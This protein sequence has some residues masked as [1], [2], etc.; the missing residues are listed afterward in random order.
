MREGLAVPKRLS[1]GGGDT[2]VPLKDG[3]SRDIRNRLRFAN[4]QLTSQ[5]SFPEEGAWDQA[6]P[7]TVTGSH[8]VET[9]PWE[10]GGVVWNRV[11][12]QVCGSPV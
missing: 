1:F 12:V 8:G 5:S 6:G 9:S 2:R 11:R 4:A 10:V 3:L 7:R